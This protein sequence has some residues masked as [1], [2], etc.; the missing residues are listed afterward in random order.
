MYAPHTHIVA[1]EHM[2]MMRQIVEPKQPKGDSSRTS[3]ELLPPWPT[4]MYVSVYIVRMQRQ[5]KVGIE[6]P[7]PSSGGTVFE[8]SDICVLF[9]Y[10]LIIMC[11]FK[12]TPWQG[13]NYLMYWYKHGLFIG[14][15]SICLSLSTNFSLN[16][17]HSKYI[18][19]LL[20]ANWVF[21]SFK[22]YK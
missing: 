3:L 16:W 21:K 11:T 19:P 14:I 12:Y 15:L 1:Y 9:S 6:H 22:Y 8:R 17:E 7:L 13:I 10:N 18:I 20:Y 2:Q 5:P 4:Y